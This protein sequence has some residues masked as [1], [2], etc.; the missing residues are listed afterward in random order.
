MLNFYK[1][2]SESLQ[3]IIK[4]L[5]LMACPLKHFEICLK[6]RVKLKKIKNSDSST[7]ILKDTK[8]AGI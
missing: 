8:I 6:R 7:A 3:Q 4:S 5:S 1:V 2:F